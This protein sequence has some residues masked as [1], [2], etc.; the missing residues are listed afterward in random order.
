MAMQKRHTH[1][2][3]RDDGGRCGFALGGRV[4]VEDCL[5]AF[6]AGRWT[7]EIEEQS[8][9]CLGRDWVWRVWRWEGDLV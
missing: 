9:C 4:G 2:K 8:P 6:A 3:L 5:A 7:A 1:I